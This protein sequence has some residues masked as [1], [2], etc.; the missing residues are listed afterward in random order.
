MRIKINKIFNK[1]NDLEGKIFNEIDK[2][3]IKKLDNVKDIEDTL[4]LENNNIESN[5]RKRRRK[6]FDE[7]I[8]KEEIEENKNLEN[9]KT[10]KIRI[11]KCL[12]NFFKNKNKLSKGY[13][14]LFL[15]MLGL[16]CGSIYIAKKTYNLFEKEDYVEYSSIS[17]SGGT[18]TVS[19]ENIALE[20]Q[21]VQANNVDTKTVEEQTSKTST[22]TSTAAKTQAAVTTTKTEVPKLVFSKPM[23]GEILKIY[24]IDKVIYSKTLELWKTHDGIDI[25]AN[26]G[27]NVKSIEKGRVEKV[28]DDS[29]YGTTVVINHGQGYK[30]RYSNLSKNVLVTD[31]Q[32]VVKGKI[33][34]T[35]G[36]TS[37]GEIKDDPHLHF[38][39]MKDN[40]IVDPSSI[41]N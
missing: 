13:Y 32:S 25:K 40:N 33:I 7:E 22:T 38:G 41:F 31:G 24:S 5:K 11:S 18:K 23:N 16:G 20:N 14:I 2:K 3:E 10:K 8:E 19:S 17:D 9:D 29:F 35:V 37:I 30:S 1:K 39:L 21:D 6:Y 12:E 34:G 27:S 15:A 4:N 36:N 28:Y 26:I